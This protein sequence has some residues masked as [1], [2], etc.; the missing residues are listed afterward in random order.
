MED[1][2]SLTESVNRALRVLRFTIH[3]GLKL[4]P[5]ELHLGRVENREPN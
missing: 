2:V 4:T 1:G 5:F 3:T